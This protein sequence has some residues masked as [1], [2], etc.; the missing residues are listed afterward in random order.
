M[1]YRWWNF[2]NLRNNGFYDPLVM[3]FS[4]KAVGISLSLAG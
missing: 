2:V 3:A 4:C 1:G